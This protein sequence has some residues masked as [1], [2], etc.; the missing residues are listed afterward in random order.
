MSF[1]KRSN[2][3][4]GTMDGGCAIPVE[5]I[6]VTDDFFTLLSIFTLLSSK[7]SLTDK[8]YSDSFG[9]VSNTDPL[10]GKRF[11]INPF[12]EISSEKDRITPVPADVTILNP[13]NSLPLSIKANLTDE[14]KSDLVKYEFAFSITY[15]PD[16]AP[17]SGLNDIEKVEK[18]LN[19][20]SANSETYKNYQN[21]LRDSF[22]ASASLTG[23]AGQ[24]NPNAKFLTEMDNFI[25]KKILIYNNLLNS[26]KE[27]FTD[28]S[29]AFSAQKAIIEDF[30]KRIDAD[31][32]E[33]KRL[34]SLLDNK[35][36]ELRAIQNN[37]YLYGG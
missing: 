17:A 8:I 18:F 35:R 5:Q 12:M 6:P 31:I 21:T 27:S 22:K 29:Y 13:F 25:D 37:A 16:G 2:F 3:L 30:Q 7:T 14:A 1:V 32:A 15:P 34:N 9:Q 33:E 28:W 20:L 24:P 23:P 26:L 11:L 19:E 4:T 36:D 10:S